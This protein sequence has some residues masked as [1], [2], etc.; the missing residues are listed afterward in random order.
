MKSEP[1]PGETDL[2]AMLGSLTID[3]R[4]GTFTVV[5]R[6]EGEEM[7]PGF[8]A[9]IKEREG[10]SIVLSV[11]QASAEGWPVVTELAWLTLAVH[12]SLESVGLTAAVSAPLADAGIACN[13]VAGYYH[14]HLLIPVNQVE[15]AT[16]LLEGLATNRRRV[17]RPPR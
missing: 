14:D 5:S 15:E 10:V 6:P 4:P 1:A 13:V 11:A 12:S 7:V 17:P 3:R 8:E 9:V 2:D 16:S